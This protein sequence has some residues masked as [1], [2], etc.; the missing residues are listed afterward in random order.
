MKERESVVALMAA[1]CALV[2][3]TG[4]TAP[5][6]RISTP[7]LVATMTTATPLPGDQI[8]ARSFV[9]SNR[10]WA[11]GTSAGGGSLIQR[12]VDGGKHWTVQ[13]RDDHRG[14]PLVGVSFVDEL[15]GWAIAST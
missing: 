6:A 9:D 15:H 2:A 13:L 8:A 7:K 1:A 14:F 5:T 12:T 11:V 4:C 3:L 10:G